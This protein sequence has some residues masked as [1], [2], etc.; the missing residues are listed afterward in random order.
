MTCRG[1]T[2]LCRQIL[3][4]RAVTRLWGWPTRVLTQASL[5]Q[6][7]LVPFGRRPDPVVVSCCR[8]RVKLTALWVGYPVSGFGMKAWAPAGSNDACAC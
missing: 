4:F 3:S 2:G 1:V 6:T 5:P 8:P 7:L